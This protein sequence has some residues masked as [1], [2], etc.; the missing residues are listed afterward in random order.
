M[1]I[2]LNTPTYTRFVWAEKYNNP[3]QV[4]CDSEGAK[5][6][7]DPAIINIIAPNH[8]SCETVFRYDIN[9]CITGATPEAKNTIRELRLDC[10]RL[11]ALRKQVVFY[12]LET[13]PDNEAA[14][15]L[16]PYTDI[17][18]Y[19]KLQPFCVAIAQNL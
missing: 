3:R 8:A 17:D 10:V 12:Y 6:S 11:V 1:P 7:K 4:H 5:G 13:N 16:Q 15:V 9:G 14:D 19:E 18:G 2:V